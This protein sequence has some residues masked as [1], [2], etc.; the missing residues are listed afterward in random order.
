MP[1]ALYEVKQKAY[2]EDQ[3]TKRYRSGIPKNDNE[4]P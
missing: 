2:E 4:K 3:E 1:K